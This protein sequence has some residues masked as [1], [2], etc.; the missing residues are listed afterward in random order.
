MEENRGLGPIRKMKLMLKVSML[1][2]A[3]MCG[4]CRHVVAE[5]GNFD[6]IALGW[7]NHNGYP[8]VVW[9]NDE[10]IMRF[11][12]GGMLHNTSN[13]P[14]RNGH[15]SLRVV[16]DGSTTLETDWSKFTVRCVSQ[17]MTRELAITTGKNEAK[18]EFDVERVRPLPTGMLPGVATE[19]TDIILKKWVL[20]FLD[21]I[22][23]KDI[24]C[25][26]KMVNDNS[27]L[28]DIE[29]CP[30]A[31]AEF[32]LQTSVADIEGLNSIHG[33]S[34]TLIFAKSGLQGLTSLC[35]SKHDEVEFRLNEF[36][37]FIDSNGKFYVRTQ[38]SKAF[39]MMSFE[40]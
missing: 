13:F 11:I 20:R 22:K 2:F 33:K 24:K 21:R 36:S 31:T 7:I 3:I 16:V 35:F 26:R 37:F 12:D 40:E 30:W 4:S 6:E 9:I 38:Q 25:L 17:G 5:N 29:F 19:K 14:L 15:N 32:K 23:A 27:G 28:P 18:T 1:A 34:C 39:A 10:P 8:T